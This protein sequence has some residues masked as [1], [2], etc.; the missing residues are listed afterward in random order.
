MIASGGSNFAITQKT[1]DIATT[2]SGVIL[3]PPRQLQQVKA[4]LE[5]TKEAEEA[6]GVN[7]GNFGKPKTTV[8]KPEEATGVNSNLI[9]SMKEKMWTILT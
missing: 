6:T 5:E 4:V 8:R 2:F 7:S 1:L 3:G 9:E